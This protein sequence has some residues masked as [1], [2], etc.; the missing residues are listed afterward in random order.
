MVT[1]GTTYYIAVDGY[2]DSGVVGAGPFRV[3]I[4]DNLVPFQ[5][6]L[7]Q[8]YSLGGNHGGSIAGTNYNATRQADE[9][10][11]INSSYPGAKSVWYRWIPTGSFGAAFELTENFDSQITVYRSTV[12]TPTFAQLT[13]VAWN[14]D[15]DGDSSSR[16]RVKFFAEAGVV[17]FIAV[18]GHSQN[19]QATDSGN[20]QL[21]YRPFR[22][23]YSMDLDARNSKA[24]IA[25][26]RPSEGNWYNRVAFDNTGYGVLRWG[27]SGDIAL[28]A[29]FT[30]DGASEHTVV[31]NENG[32]KVW[33]IRTTPAPTIVQ[34]GL[35]SDR[36]VVGD[37]DGDSRADMTVIRNSA[38]GFVW[39]VRQSSNGALR[40][41]TFGTTSDR[42]ILGDFNGDGVTEVAVVRNTANGL[43]WYVLHSSAPGFLPFTQWSGAQFGQAPDVPA[44][45]DFD[46]DGKTDIAVFRPSTGTWYILQ[47]SNWQVRIDA[48]GLSG[49]KPQPAD[50]NGDGKADLCVFRPLDGTW[51]I[52]RPTGIPG[53]NYDT[54]HWGLATDIPVSSLTTLSQ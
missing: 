24:S 3:T 15:S 20:F 41:F 5:D 49:D 8:Y 38:Q 35:S 6:D 1:A 37:F 43:V 31:R 32:H 2:N 22:M 42:P 39:Y 19:P 26:Y 51:Y 54:V 7:A 34:W 18:A 46:G 11:H 44:A 9:P 17:Y 14:I 23:K 33:Y 53:Q 4:L 50:Y 36:A 12:Q 29:D 30:G 13:R 16:Y 10:D 47:S 21:T 45:E 28:A 25:V 52:A 27:L 48:F 40:T